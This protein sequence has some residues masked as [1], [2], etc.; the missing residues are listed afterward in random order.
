MIFLGLH[1][2]GKVSRL[3]PRA[4]AIPQRKVPAVAATAPPQR[5]Q[6][7]AAPRGRPWH[8]PG[9]GGGPAVGAAPAQP[10]T[11]G[12][13]ASLR[14]Q[15]PRHPQPSP[16]GAPSSV[17]PRSSAG[18]G[19]Q[20]RPPARPGRIQ[21]ALPCPALPRHGGKVSAESQDHRVSLAGNDLQISEIIKSSLCFNT[22]TSIRPWHRVPRTGFPSIP[23]GMVSPS[24]F[25]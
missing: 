7:P 5:P 13:F 14:R 20:H 23:P 21:P 3:P 2:R 4:G 22:A 15:L 17:P 25:Q 8:G 16:E 11:A 9:P 10:G 1:L 24:L 18:P 19:R 6:I 12:T